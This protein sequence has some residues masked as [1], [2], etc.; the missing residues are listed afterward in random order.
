MKVV[1][2]FQFYLPY[3]LP[4]A[5]D[6]K[7]R[8]FAF[9]SPGYFVEVHPREFDEE[10]F[11][12]EIDK[13]LS[14][15]TLTLRRLSLP[16]SLVCYTT[17]DRC[18]DRI[19]VR[20]RGELAPAGDAKEIT[21]QETFLEVAIRCC[22]ILLGHCR[23]ASGT[24]F[25]TGI[26]RNYRPADKRYYIITPYSV[27]WFDADAGIPVPAYSGDANAA[28]SGG[29]VSSPE[30][31]SVS[32]E[33]IVQSL[34]KGEQPD[35]AE[36]LLIDAE[37]MIVTQRLREAIIAQGTACEVAGDEYLRRTGK[38]A[39]PNVKRIIKS[40]DSFA[41]KRFHHIPHLVNGRSLKRED[42]PTFQVIEKL[43]RTRNSLVHEG[44]LQYVEAGSVIKVNQ[45]I[46]TE[47]LEASR[48]AVRW[49]ATP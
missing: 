47:F 42:P 22:N 35:L 14:T 23:V 4:R 5:D 32:M 26:Q 31:G 41:E 20:V 27:T 2:I 24:A 9:D 19:E 38:A 11:P 43:Y 44:T 17:K 18:Y 21:T 34:K 48:R 3:V 10:L 16:P 12:G 6:W 49:L 8:R 45:S 39:D 15:T 37:E 7:Q 25:I 30:R 1:A 33:L 28:C 36:S 29:A 40:Q 46:A 13:T